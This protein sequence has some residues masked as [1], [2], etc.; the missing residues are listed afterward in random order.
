MVRLFKR[1]R[2]TCHSSGRGGLRHDLAGFCGTHFKYRHAAKFGVVPLNMQIYFQ[3]IIILFSLTIFFSCTA[4]YPLKA[5]R[6]ILNMEVVEIP[7]AGKVAYLEGDV[8][9]LKKER[10]T[11]YEKVAVGT[12]AGEDDILW[13]KPGCRLKIEFEDG[14]YIS[15]EKQGKEVFA[16]FK[17]SKTQ[18][19][20]KE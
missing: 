14:S 5:V 10:I 13:M 8:E 12:I 15:N 17:F 20:R 6:P 4:T 2:R 1:L 9:I 3:Q 19:G 16:T 11:G 18:D 7:S